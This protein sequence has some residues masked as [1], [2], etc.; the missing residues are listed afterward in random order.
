MGRRYTVRI[1]FYQKYCQD[2]EKELVVA[3]RW[4]RQARLGFKCSIS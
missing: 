2:V 1:A 4:G 3:L